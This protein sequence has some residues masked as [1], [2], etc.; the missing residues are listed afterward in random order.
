MPAHLPTISLHSHV[1]NEAPGAWAVTYSHGPGV[2]RYTLRFEMWPA[3]CAVSARLRRR[4]TSTAPAA[5]P[6]ITA[7]LKDMA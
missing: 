2:V 4:F 5:T 3:L 6:S 1:V 7:K